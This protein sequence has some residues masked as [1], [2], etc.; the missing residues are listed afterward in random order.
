MYDKNFG[1]TKVCTILKIERERIR[2]W[3]LTG[4]ITPSIPAKGQGT[5]SVFYFK[6]M[7][8]ILLFKRLIERGFKRE[9]AK[10]Y[11]DAL[12]KEYPEDERFP[13]NVVF[14]FSVSGKDVTIG[15]K[16]MNDVTSFYQDIVN[17]RAI[18]KHILHRIDNIY[19][20]E[21]IKYTDNLK[22]S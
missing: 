6:D 7:V 21:A 13:E 1:M 11:I 19:K 5:K 16:P 18:V 10:K 22:E 4:D 3:I 2:N 9:L 20:L 8:L 12:K 17:M 14:F 15:K